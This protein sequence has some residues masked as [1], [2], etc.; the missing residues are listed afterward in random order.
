[1]DAFST[2]NPDHNLPVAY[3]TQSGFDSGLWK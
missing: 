3:L 2:F 1:M